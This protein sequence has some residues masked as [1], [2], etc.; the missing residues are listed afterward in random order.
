MLFTKIVLLGALLYDNLQSAVLDTSCFSAFSSSSELSV[1]QDNRSSPLVHVMACSSIVIA[2]SSLTTAGLMGKFYRP[3]YQQQRHWRSE[4]KVQVYSAYR[5]SI[6]AVE[7]PT[8]QVYI[9]SLLRTTSPVQRIPQPT[10][11]NR[12]V[13]PTFEWTPKP[14]PQTPAPTPI[15]PAEA[16]R[17]VSQR[18]PLVVAW[19]SLAVAMAMVLGGIVCFAEEMDNEHRV[20]VRYL[21]SLLHPFLSL[22]PIIDSSRCCCR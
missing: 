9:P 3:R 8:S 2:A 12:H 21:S 10:S 5:A 16:P 22:I 19:F 11:I 7:P 6:P 13:H 4:P 14:R 20:E 18:L 17:L 15:P 1:A